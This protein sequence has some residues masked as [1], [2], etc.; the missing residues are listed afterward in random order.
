MVSHSVRV[1]DEELLSSEVLL[2]RTV[3]NYFISLLNTL[4]IIFPINYLAYRISNTKKRSK[5]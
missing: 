3:A 1:S 4:L 5:Y 2:T